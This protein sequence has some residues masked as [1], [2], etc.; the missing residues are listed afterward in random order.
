MSQKLNQ[1]YALLLLPLLLLKEGR[2]QDIEQTANQLKATLK[3]D[4]LTITGSLGANTVF[5][6][7]QGISPRRDPF[8]YV[9]NANLN[10]SLFNKIS[11]PLSA[12]ITQQDKNFSKG[13]LDKFS[14]PFNQFGISPKYKWLTLH[15]GYRSLQFSDYSLSGAMFL[16][17]GIEVKPDK[18]IISASAFMGRFVKAVPTGGVAGVVVSLPAYERWGGGAKIRIGKDSNYGECSY[19]KIKDKVN[20]IAFDTSLFIT[21]HDNQIFGFATRQKI[22]KSL[23]LSSDLCYS[24]FTK[25]LYEDVTKLEKFSYINQIY[26]PR[27]SSQFNKALNASI[28]YNP[29]KFTLGLKYKRIDPDYRSL[30]AIF[31]TN[32]VQEISF[33][34]GLSLLKNKLSLQASSGIQTNNLDKVQITTSRRIIGYFN[35]SYNVSPQFNINTGYSN[36]SSNTIPVRDVFTD[37]IKFV[38][39][40]QNGNLQSTFV[41]GSDNIK[42]TLSLSNTYQESANNKQGLNTFLNQTLSYNLSFTKLALGI[43]TSLLY[44]RSTTAGFATNEGIGPNL[45]IQK[46]FYKNKIQL[47]LSSGFQMAYSDKKE[48]NKNLNSNVSFSYTIDKN[49]SLKASCGFLK[50]I[51]L[52]QSAQAFIE[53]RASLGYQYNFGAR[54]KSPIKSINT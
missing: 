5:Y 39:L 51:A 17:G 45:G 13:S 10:I 30:G 47:R 6:T 15:L 21:P 20:S 42:Q 46:S 43:N 38:Q 22:T 1:K 52:Q 31:L 53:Q 23:S 27:P 54:V 2:A 36:F 9:F 50:R 12:V 35:V 4:P 16:G 40:T 41:F 26:A 49:Q 28:D 44:N 25:N 8:Y 14:Q 11:M 37:S 19:L 29:G 24:M 7:A 32:D 48:L 33:N 18:S 3:Q 34:S